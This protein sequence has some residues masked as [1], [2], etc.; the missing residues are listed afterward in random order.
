MMEENYPDATLI[1]DIYHA[2]SDVGEAANASF[3]KRKIASE[4]IEIGVIYN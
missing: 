3:T 2:M 1:Q 4:W